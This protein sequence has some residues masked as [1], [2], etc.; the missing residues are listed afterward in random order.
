[1][2]RFIVVS[3]I[4]IALA[5]LVH[6]MPYAGLMWKFSRGL[7]DKGYMK[8][9]GTLVAQISHDA[10]PHGSDLH[11]PY[12]VHQTLAH[13]DTEID[14]HHLAGRHLH[15]DNPPRPPV[16]SNHKSFDAI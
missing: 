6:H 7:A 16:W 1:M 10:G 12:C 9:G 13:P 14:S 2:S 8:R 3:L 11:P 4:K 15:P 5:V